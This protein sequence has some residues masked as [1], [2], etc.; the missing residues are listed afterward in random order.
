MNKNIDLLYIVLLTGLCWSLLMVG[1]E[2][3]G[4]GGAVLLIGGELISVDAMYLTHDISNASFWHEKFV[5]AS[6]SFI[7]IIFVGIAVLWISKLQK[8]HLGWVI[9]FG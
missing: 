1:H 9:F 6:G 2:I 4:H 7:N 3:I 5:K 8:N